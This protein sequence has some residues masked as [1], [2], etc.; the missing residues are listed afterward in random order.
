MLKFITQSKLNDDLD[1]DFFTNWLGLD[2]NIFFV[3]LTSFSIL[4]IANFDFLTVQVPIILIIL[5]SNFYSVYA[6]LVLLYAATILS[7]VPNGVQV[8][9]NFLNSKT[10]IEDLDLKL[11]QLSVN[12][13]RT[14]LFL[15]TSACILAVD[16]S[17]FSI[18]Y[19][20]THDFGFGLMDIGVG[21]FVL[22]H[23]M[24]LIRNSNTEIK[25]KNGCEN[26]LNAVK[27][28]TILLIL[29]ILRLIITKMAGYRVNINEYGEHWNF[30]FT[31][32]FV[33]KLKICFFIIKKNTTK[34]RLELSKT[35]NYGFKKIKIQSPDLDF[36]LGLNEPDYI[37]SC[38][39]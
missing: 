3:L 27:S 29:G 5:A 28:S 10:Q 13:F 37:Y 34:T 33:K 8:K 30:F 26:I 22:S 31:I 9:S 12:E 23:S 38:F 14:F 25:V 18:D 16:F 36:N 7:L 39:F 15:I 1:M 32:Y 6:S 4:C 19:M 11:I 2:I 35:L 21:Y 17:Y 24:R 20:K